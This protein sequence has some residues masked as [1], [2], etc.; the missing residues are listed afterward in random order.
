M[1]PA[2]MQHPYAFALV[3]LATPLIATC[4]TTF[5]SV[6]AE[7]NVSPPSNIANGFRF[8]IKC[9]PS[10]CAHSTAR[11]IGCLRKNY[12]DAQSTLCAAAVHSFIETESAFH[13]VSV[14]AAD[15][16]ICNETFNA[17]P[18]VSTQ[19]PSSVA[20]RFADA[21]TVMGAQS[22]LSSTPSATVIGEQLRGYCPP[23]IFYGSNS[24][25]IVGCSLQNVYTA[26]SLAC[27]VAMHAGV[28]SSLMGGVFRA[29]VVPTPTYFCGVAANFVSASPN[30]IVSSDQVA[31]A[32]ELKPNTLGTIISSL[33]VFFLPSTPF[34]LHA[35]LKNFTAE[36]TRSHTRCLLP[37]FKRSLPCS[38]ICNLR[39]CWEP[40]FVFGLH[41]RPAIPT[42][43]HTKFVPVCYRLEFC[44]G[45]FLHVGTRSL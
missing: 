14:P 1:P 20:W 28:I 5:A 10:A 2:T 15:A 17:I 13:I 45:I 21:P 25:S 11:V 30:A 29:N 19:S 36:Q 42:Q 23:Y 41:R 7:N 33:I 44:N 40:I 16:S 6:F 18:P 12:F 34:S 22:P 37:F 43:T 8:P 39:L 24:T 26:E 3:Y 38:S 27:L 9:P 32:L 31:F 4:T 35:L